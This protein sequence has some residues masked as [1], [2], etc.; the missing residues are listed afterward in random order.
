MKKYHLITIIDKCKRP[1]RMCKKI[2]YDDFS[3]MGTK[4]T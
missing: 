1:M 3:N 2:Y 4:T